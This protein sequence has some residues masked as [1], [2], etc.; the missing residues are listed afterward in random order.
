MKRHLIHTDS[1]KTAIFPGKL[2]SVNYS[3]FIFLLRLFLDGGS[4]EE[5]LVVPLAWFAAKKLYSRMPFIM[6]TL[7][8]LTFLHSL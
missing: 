8:A 7:Q 3:S 6:P 2:E 1:F 5:F 4:L